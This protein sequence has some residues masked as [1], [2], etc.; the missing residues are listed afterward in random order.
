ME[1]NTN[2]VTEE[3]NEVKT[4]TQ[5]EVD[6]IKN[7]MKEDYEKSFDE[8]FN[9]R[10]GREKNKLERSNAKTNEL[11]DLLKKETGKENIDDLLSLSYEQYGV[12]RPNKESEKD[13]EV[14][15][16]YDAKEFL[17][18]DDLDEIQ[19]EANRL[20]ELPNRTVREQ[21]TFNELA[22]YL[23]AKKSEAKR[24]LEIEE[25][26]LDKAILENEDFKEYMSKFKEDTPL[27]FIYDSY[28]QIH[29]KE[30]PFTTGSLQGTNV[31]NKN[32][33][34]DF[35]TY[36][37]S[38]QFTKKDFDKNPALWKV[39]QESMPQWSKK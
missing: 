22:K 6:A 34:K 16:K 9:K 28:S 27:K 4:F 8:K 32:T 23:T 7:Q 20:A 14:L 15:G 35:Y 5:E 19:E 12:E 25:N 33:V 11:I 17:D 24:N 26:G 36:E 31:E 18:L 3:N 37:E 10:W 1:E 29:K 21:A 39:I 13:E 38:L 30:K 2:V